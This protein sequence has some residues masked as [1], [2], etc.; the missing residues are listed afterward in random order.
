MTRSLNK[1]CLV[2]L[3]AAGEYNVFSIH[4]SLQV[5]LRLDLDRNTERR[6]AI[7]NHAISVIRNAA[8]RASPLQIPDPAQWPQFQR[9]NP[10]ALALCQAFNN[11]EPP[12]DPSVGL[13]DLLYNAGFH[14]W[15]R[16]NPI[17]RDG[18]LLLE[19]AEKILDML[20]Y[21][22]N[23][24]IRADIACIM[25]LLFD[26]MGLSR[27]SESLRRRQGVYTTRGAILQQ[28]SPEEWSQNEHLYYNATND[29]GLSYLQ[30]DEFLKAG[31][32]FD[33]CFEKYKEWGTEISIPYEY[34]KYY[35]NMALVRMYQGRYGEAIAM[36]E[37]GIPIKK[38]TDG[39]DNSRYWWFNYDIASIMLQ[40]GELDRALE[41]H[42]EVLA[43]RQRICGE[44]QEVTLQSLYTVGAMY[45]HLN[46]RA[47]AE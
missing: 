16:W 45:Y 15:E 5:A 24:R 6:K 44:S 19:T 2:H 36:S 42:L 26:L 22:P 11:S 41:R 27:R 40:A 12:L 33:S 46:D 31:E 34:A 17:T 25:S 3:E 30:N 43:N 20:Q 21:D 8:P 4:R 9:T 18:T 14:V 29:L 47:K 37:K 13:A 7:F 39:I 28:S 35:H 23:S 1:R 38:T 10:H 32:L